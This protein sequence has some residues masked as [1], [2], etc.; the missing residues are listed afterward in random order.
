NWTRVGCLRPW[1]VRGTEKVRFTTC[2]SSI[3][4]TT[5]SGGL[6]R[7]SDAKESARGYQAARANSELARIVGRAIRRA[8]P[9]RFVVLACSRIFKDE[10]RRFRRG[11][12]EPLR[13]RSLTPNGGQSPRGH[14]GVR[15]RERVA[16]PRDALTVSTHRS[17][18]AHVLVG[19][20]QISATS[21]TH[22]R[23]LQHEIT[24][25]ERVM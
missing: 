8:T 17:V 23:A 20:V 9:D 18:R 13:G 2:W 7:S 3:N 10:N 24:T 22:A 5:Q 25:T 15:D 14:F 4:A 6:P 11:Q 16:G 19:V 12:R 21:L 1:D